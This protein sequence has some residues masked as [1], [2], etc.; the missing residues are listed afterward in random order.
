MPDSPTPALAPIV[1]TPNPNADG[2]LPK[3]RIVVAAVLSSFI[4]GLGQ[5]LVHRWL[6]GLLFFL[7]LGLELVLYWWLR[8]PRTLVGAI[9][10][11]LAVIALGVLA[12]WDAAYAGKSGLAKPSQWCR[13]AAK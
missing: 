6:R 11:I 2:A 7:A 5:F 10:P 1:T 4:P 13:F 8:L 12:A 9:I 3:G